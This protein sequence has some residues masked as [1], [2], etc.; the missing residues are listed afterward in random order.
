SRWVPLCP[1]SR[2]AQ[3]ARL[4]NCTARS[5]F[6]AASRVLNVPRF[7]RFPVRESFFCEYSR[8]SP[9]FNLRIITGTP[10][11]RQPVSSFTPNG[12]KPQ[13]PS[14][15]RPS[16]PFLLPRPSYRRHSSGYLRSGA[17]RPEIGPDIEREDPAP[18]DRELVAE[19]CIA[20]NDETRKQRPAF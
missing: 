8:Y 14:R 1:L 4:K 6:S 19:C 12:A 20:A 2:V 11:S 10:S 15:N 3:C 16:G 7:F 18:E 13:C 9:L 5:C 17:C